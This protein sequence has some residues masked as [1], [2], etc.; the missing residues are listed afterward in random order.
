[1]HAEA[2]S[3]KFKIVTELRHNIR[4][5]TCCLLVFWE[6]IAIHKNVLSSRM[7]VQIA[8]KCD[9]PLLAE[10]FNEPLHIEHDWMQN[11]IRCFPT[12]IHILSTQAAPVVSIYDSVW[13]EHR[14]YLEN[15]LFT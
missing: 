1:M 11:F 10:I 7:T 2:T 5:N 6:I 12:S 3:F 15:K 4:E 9:F 13:I 14:N 8:K